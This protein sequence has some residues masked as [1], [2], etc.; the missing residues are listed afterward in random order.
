M[1]FQASGPPWDMTWSR[2]G[3]TVIAGRAYRDRFLIDPVLEE[4]VTNRSE[5]KALN[6]RL[7]VS[8][9]RNTV[10]IC[11]DRPSSMEIWSNGSGPVLL[12]LPEQIG[13]FALSNEH[14]LCGEGPEWTLAIH[15]LATGDHRS[16]DVTGVAAIRPLSGGRA[17]VGF[18]SSVAVLDLS[19]GARLWEAPV[20]G[21]S[22]SPSDYL[23]SFPCFAASDDGRWLAAS[24]KLISR[25]SYK[26]GFKVWNTEDGSEVLAQTSAKGL[27]ALAFSPD[28]DLASA[29]GDGAVRLWSAG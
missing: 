29:A 25:G 27:N 6:M 10:A 1:P 7:R 19:S 26:S 16:L 8:P 4:V 24:C 15:D 22:C 21:V 18:G 3:I 11:Y 2:S 23:P 9:D 12:E 17:A 13:G 5:E 28:G 14:L 20:Q